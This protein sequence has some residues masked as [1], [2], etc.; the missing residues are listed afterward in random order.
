MCVCVYT[1]HVFV[2]LFASFFVSADSTLV[3]SITTITKTPA[4]TTNTATT[5]ADETSTTSNGSLPG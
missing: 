5:F 4:T 2:H 1:V 3:D